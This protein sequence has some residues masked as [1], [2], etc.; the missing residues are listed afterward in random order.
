MNRTRSIE[1][2]QLP[3]GTIIG[4]AVP[5]TW[6]MCHDGVFSMHTAIYSDGSVWTI[7]ADN[8]TWPSTLLKD[9]FADY[10]LLRNATPDEAQAAFGHVIKESFEV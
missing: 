6:Y 8:R 5:A 7:R 3:N 10:V 4:H 2:E 9:E 1:A